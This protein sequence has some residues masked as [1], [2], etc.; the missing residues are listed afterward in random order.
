MSK[1]TL[2]SFYHTQEIINLQREFPLKNSS[3][4]R[5]KVQNDPGKSKTKSQMNSLPVLNPTKN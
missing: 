3:P 1:Q 5:A 4:L 2:S